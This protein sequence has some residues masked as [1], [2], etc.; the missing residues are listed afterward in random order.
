MNE[1]PLVDSSD[2][3]PGILEELMPTDR[4]G[5]SIDLFAYFKAGSAATCRTT[6]GRLLAVT[7]NGVS[8]SIGFSAEGLTRLGVD[9]PLVAALNPPF[10]A[11]ARV[12]SELLDDPEPSTWQVL[13]HGFDIVVMLTETAPPAE[14][15]LGP[16]PDPFGPYLSAVRAC[17]TVITLERGFLLANRKEAFGFKDGVTNPV[18]SGTAQPMTDGNGVRVFGGWRPLAAGEI[19]CGYPDE[20]GSLP[21]PSVT[22]EITRNGSYLVWRKLEQNV[23]V[24]AEIVRKV[25][26]SD[27]SGAWEGRFCTTCAESIFGRRQNG[28]PLNRSS[29]GDNGFDYREP[30]S[31]GGGADINSHI[32]RA[33]PRSTKGFAPNTVDRHRIMRRSVRWSDEDT[34]KQGVLWSDDQTKKQGLLFRCYQSDIANGFE[35]IQRSWMNTGESFANG[36]TVDVIVG[37][38]KS[39]S[40][41]PLDFQRT[42]VHLKKRIP[43]RETS[44]TQVLGMAYAFVPGRLTLDRLATSEMWMSPVVP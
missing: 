24:F 10:V 38:S 36:R 1:T 39:I 18:L 31:S 19:V 17:F 30:K 7:S 2:V 21:G 44:P 42:T 29:S 12:R 22:H 5:K 9:A 32:R 25:H 28:E 4:R 35:F 20:S 34:N 41:D 33:N 8:A 23:E 27:H 16:G 15:T 6:L 11:G 3:Q 26:D 40:A 43:A 14:T 13:G 37:Q